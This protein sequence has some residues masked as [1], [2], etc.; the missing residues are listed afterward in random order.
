MQNT[1][2][3]PPPLTSS[4]ALPNTHKEYPGFL[5]NFDSALNWDGALPTVTMAHRVE[6]IDKE[7]DAY[8]KL[9]AIAHSVQD[10]IGSVFS[11]GMAGVRSEI[12]GRI[13]SATDAH[14]S[15]KL[16]GA[17]KKKI[18]IVEL[19]QRVRSNRSWHEADAFFVRDP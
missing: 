13:N 2:A 8:S 19:L 16:E 6:T 14:P 3:S 10:Q 7:P 5:P 17:L 11:N 9:V 18:I 4:N 12:E 1:I 15:N